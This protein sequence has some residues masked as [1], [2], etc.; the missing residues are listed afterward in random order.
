MISQLDKIL[1]VEEEDRTQFLMDMGKRIPDMP[2]EFKIDKNRVH[3][4]MSVVYF[5]GYLLDGRLK[6]LA[7]SDSYFVRGLIWIVYELFN[8]KTIL[9][10]RSELDRLD[11]SFELIGL[12]RI[13]SMRRRMGLNGIIKCI[14]RLVRDD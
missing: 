9:N 5:Y 2:E 7:T 11:S 1:E 13:V 4:C 14:E 6:F 8:D 12:S 10:V 3:G